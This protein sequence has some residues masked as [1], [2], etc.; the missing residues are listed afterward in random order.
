MNSQTITSVQKIEVISNSTSS[1]VQFGDRK[2]STLSNKSISVLQNKPSCFSGDPKFED[3]ALF[4]QPVPE[5]LLAIPP[6]VK[7]IKPTLPYLVPLPTLSHTIEIDE[8]DIISSSDSSN[9][10]L[11]NGIQL[12]SVNRS[13]SFQQYFD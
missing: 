5:H 9:I 6:I 11:G 7:L 8:I 3:Y 1:I 12:L 13:K 2:N 10:Q 4:I